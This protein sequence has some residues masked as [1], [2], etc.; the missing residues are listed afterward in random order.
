MAYLECTFG[1]QHHIAVRFTDEGSQA[2]GGALPVEAVVDRE[3]SVTVAAL[4]V[5]PSSSRPAR[6]MVVIEK[7]DVRKGPGDETMS[8]A[9][10]GELSVVF[11]AVTRCTEKLKA[12]RRPS[13]LMNPQPSARWA[14][15]A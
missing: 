15:A 9:G 6:H 3:D 1:L 12:V 7:L 13:F 11:V 10:D 14:G 5:P 2:V 4:S 8:G